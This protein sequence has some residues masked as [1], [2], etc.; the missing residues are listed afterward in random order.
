MPVARLFVCM[1]GSEH[2]HFIERLSRQLQADRHIG[3][4][5]PAR[6]RYS[7]E[8]VDVVWSLSLIHI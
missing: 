7:W 1:G 8:P 6:N 5:K 4:G 2:C 3:I